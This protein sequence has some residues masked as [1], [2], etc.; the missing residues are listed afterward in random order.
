[1]SEEE[2][3]KAIEIMTQP[4]TV[5]CVDHHYFDQ[6]NYD[7]LASASD[8]SL[9]L[10][11]PYES[12][13]KENKQ[14]K[15]LINGIREERDYLF[16]KSSVENKQIQQEKDLYKSVIEEVREY[17]NQIIKDT[18]DFYRPTEDVIYSGDTLIDLAETNIQILDKV[19]DVK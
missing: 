14:L 19:K 17:N 2:L 4:I 9:W 6:E 18:K 11:K 15:E 10:L 16:N 7:K 8:S 13:L 12:I 5:N 3:Q 1:M